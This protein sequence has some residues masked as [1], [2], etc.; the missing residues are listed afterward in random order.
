MRVVFFLIKYVIIKRVVGLQL[1]FFMKKNE[2]KKD[3]G[4]INNI[5]NK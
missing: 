1:L 3:T 2:V 5:M 4:F